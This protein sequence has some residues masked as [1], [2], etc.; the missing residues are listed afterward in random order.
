MF[1]DFSHSI[2]MRTGRLPSSMLDAP[3]STQPMFL[4]SVTQVTN[5]HFVD[6]YSWSSRMPGNFLF[7]SLT[8]IKNLLNQLP[9]G[10]LASDLCE[11]SLRGAMIQRVASNHPRRP[12][13][14]S[15]QLADFCRSHVPRFSLKSGCVGCVKDGFQMVSVFWSCKDLF[16]SFSVR[17]FKVRL[18]C[19][20]CHFF[21][22]VHFLFWHV[23]RPMDS[24][25][26]R[27][28]SQDIYHQLNKIK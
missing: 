5:K 19:S 7:H 24:P 15:G 12:D 2:S 4:G 18:G 8:A 13:R 22:F 17:C 1:H 16:A 27:F 20:T 10:N 25:W 11:W 14:C 9:F 6:Q 26:A 28:F 23:V 3:S 21:E